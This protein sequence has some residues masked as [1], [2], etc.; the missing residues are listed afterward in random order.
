MR[1]DSKNRIQSDTW[2]EWI[3]QD[4]EGQLASSDKELLGQL[5]E[6]DQRI[7]AERQ[8]LASLHQMLG[9][10][11]IEVRSGFSAQVMQALPKAWWEREVATG[12]LARWVLPLAM[13]FALAFGAAGVLASADEFGPLAGIGI[14]LL[15]FIQ[16]SI[17]AG[18]GMLFATWRGLGFGLEHFMANSGLNLLALASAVGFLNLLFFSLLRRR[19]PV[20]E[21]G[22]A[23]ASGLAGSVAD[24]DGR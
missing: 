3:D 7:A 4:L 17:L 13:M 16:V 5:D 1:T 10:S 2:K 20:A 24:Q 14:A 12:G 19:V 21:A 18:A 6:A 8:A 11:R 15:D 22:D 23:T 9:E